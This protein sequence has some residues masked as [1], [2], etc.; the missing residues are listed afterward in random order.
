MSNPN[1]DMLVHLSTYSAIGNVLWKYLLS[2][3]FKV[4]YHRAMSGGSVK[5]SSRL[6]LDFG[7]GFGRSPMAL[8]I[9]L[10]GET[11]VFLIIK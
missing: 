7:L 1:V 9:E 11:F 4:C 6:W 8:R 10:R 3:V 2:V 5:T